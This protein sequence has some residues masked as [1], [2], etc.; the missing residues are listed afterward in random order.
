MICQG[1]LQCL[2]LRKYGFLREQRQLCRHGFP[3]S[4]S[5]EGRDAGRLTQDFS[6]GET[7]A[8]PRHFPH[9]EGNPA[10]STIPILKM[11]TKPVL[12]CHHRQEFEKEEERDNVGD[13]D[14]AAQLGA[15]L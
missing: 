4:A 7:H 13:E 12:S 5:V 1:R 3:D 10:N 9:R 2:R 8:N 6:G 11:R 15:L 14:V